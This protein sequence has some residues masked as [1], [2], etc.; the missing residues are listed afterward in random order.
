MVVVTGFGLTGNWE[1]MFDVVG[2]LWEGDG[3]FSDPLLAVLYILA[4]FKMC[5]FCRH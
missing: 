3:S 1:W 2:V 4:S 5:C